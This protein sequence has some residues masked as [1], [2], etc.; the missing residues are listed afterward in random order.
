MRLRRNVVAI[1]VLVGFLLA[2]AFHDN[3]HA[4]ESASA[5][6]LLNLY[7]PNRGN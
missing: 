1:G 3:A 2:L 5:V 4:S 7:D 6:V